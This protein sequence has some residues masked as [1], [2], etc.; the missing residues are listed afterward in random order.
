MPSLSDLITQLRG[1]AARVRRERGKKAYT[2]RPRPA[3][4]GA[5][6][7]YMAFE[8]AVSTSAHSHMPLLYEE[9]TSNV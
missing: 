9:R 4:I 7:Q 6:S 3:S 1:D 8:H 5:G 2:K